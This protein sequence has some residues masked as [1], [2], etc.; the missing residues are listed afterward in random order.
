MFVRTGSLR[1]WARGWHD[2]AALAGPDTAGLTLAAARWL[3]EEKGAILVGSDT[4]TVEVIPPLDG[5]NVSPVH[6][7]LL[8]D[9]GVHMAELHW[10]EEL[11][12]DRPYASATSPSRRSCAGRRAASLC[13]R[14]RLSD[15][16]HRQ[17]PS[18]RSPPVRVGRTSLHVPRS[19]SGPARSGAGRRRCRPSRPGDDRR[20]WDVGFRLFRHRAVLRTRPLGGAPRRGPERRCARGLHLSTK[21]GRL[22]VAGRPGA[23]L[24]KG[25][26]TAFPSTTSRTRRPALARGEPRAARARA[27]DMRLI[28]DPDDHHDEALGASYRALAEF[29]ADGASGDRAGMN[30]SQ[31]LT[32]FA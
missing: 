28:H 30:W 13:D 24:F 21:V 8:V 9:Q 6:K 4:S 23:G 2:H 12:R 26:R 3:V 31:P 29:R 20:A 25:S 18:I 1:H 15:G 19:A 32:R 22:L 11:A 27:I 5:D 7:Y 14:S 17:R 16:E 10:L